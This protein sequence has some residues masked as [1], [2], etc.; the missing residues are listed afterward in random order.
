MANLNNGNQGH[1]KNRFKKGSSGNPGGR[2]RALD[3]EREAKRLARSNTLKAVK[4]LVALIDDKNPRVAIAA[5][6]AVLD[7]S[8]GKP[9]Q[10]EPDEGPQE[11]AFRSLPLAEQLARLNAA[12]VATEAELAASV[13]AGPK[14]LQAVEE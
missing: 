5:S 14:L 4:R 3:E 1:A 10:S 9:C 6:T 13:A 8:W 12:C 7:R 11:H 2:R